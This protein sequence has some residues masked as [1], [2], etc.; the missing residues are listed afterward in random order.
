MSE[1]LTGAEQLKKELFMKPV[2]AAKVCTEAQI[3]EADNFCEGYMS[4]LDAAKTEREAVEEAVALARANGFIEYRKG[5]AYQPGEKV[6]Y[7]NRGKALILAVTGTLGLSQGARIAAAHID[8]PRLDLKPNPLYEDGD[9]A[10]MK[11]HYY[12]GIK[13][14]QWT[15]LPLAL[16]GVM[17][18]RDGSSVEV[19]IGEDDGDPK[20]VIS[21]LLIHIAAEQMKET[22]ADGV[23]AESLN[24]LVGSRPFDDSEEA[25]NVK[26]N[27]L[28]ILF[29]KYGVTEEDFLSAELEAVPALKASDVGF[30]RSMIG[31]YGHDDRVC[32]YTA[33][34]ALLD[35][36][37]PENTAVCVLTDKEET[38]S[39]GNTGMDSAYLANFISGLAKSEGLDGAAVLSMS[40]ALSTDV[41]SAYDPTYPG[42]F[43]KK[44]CSY[45]NHGAVIKKYT[46]A[47]GKSNASDASAELVGK[48]RKRLNDAGIPWQT[49]EIGRVDLGGGGT[50][51]R[52]I[53]ALD[54]DVVDLGVPLLSMHAPY[55]VVAKLDV[56][57]VYRAVLEFFKG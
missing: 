3:R 13:K 8:S 49:G 30:D 14:Y 39:Q 17:I 41:N 42:S 52:F 22:L 48:L 44:N 47:K 36:E 38:G 56:F 15:V 43:E 5:E 54:V 53:A 7:N 46:G 26:L 9:L 45:L 29:E 37:E 57:A 35:T 6:Y 24:L 2:N 33:L 34:M 55:E 12:G 28:R 20:F 40:E 51:A 31:A 18:R 16:H 23:K 4:F 19:N 11:T 32:A 21:D 1:E 25:Q 27:V 10:L 50:V